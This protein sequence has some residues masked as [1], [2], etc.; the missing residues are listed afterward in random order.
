MLLVLF[1]SCALVSAAMLPFLPARAVGVLLVG[2]VIFLFFLYAGPIRLMSDV[3]ISNEGISRTLLGRPW[4]SIPWDGVKVIKV[5]LMVD[6]RLSWKTRTLRLFD[7]IPK[8]KDRKTLR[9]RI[10]FSEDANDMPRLIELLNRHIAAH[11]IRVEIYRGS[12]TLIATP[13]QISP[14][15][16]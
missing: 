3:I 8:A 1:T 4:Q 16:T 9:T 7:I 15:A 6:P 2:F 12:R 13:D 14:V 10:S 5:G 11:C